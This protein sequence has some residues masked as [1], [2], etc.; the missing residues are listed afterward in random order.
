MRSKIAAAG[1]IEQVMVVM[2]NQH[3]ADAQ[4][5]A[6]WSLV[7]LANSNQTIKRR[8]LLQAPFRA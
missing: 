1:G 8:L 7:N 3:D 4:A 6:C 2:D 5:K